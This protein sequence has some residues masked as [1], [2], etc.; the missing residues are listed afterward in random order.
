[1]GGV[2]AEGVRERTKLSPPAGFHDITRCCVDREKRGEC[3]KHSSSPVFG[4][5]GLCVLGIRDQL[6]RG[7]W[8]GQHLSICDSWKCWCRM[9]HGL[10]GR[11]GEQRVFGVV[12]LPSVVGVLPHSGLLVAFS[13][14]RL[15][16]GPCFCDLVISW[17]TQGQ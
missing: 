12:F 6:G 9:G 15:L 11:G 4:C 8:Q 10:L 16:A 7:G 2:R 13:K 3:Q 14:A 17:V 5:D 1:M